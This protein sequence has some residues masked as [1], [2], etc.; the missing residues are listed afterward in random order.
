MTVY[1][2]TAFVQAPEK[3]YDNKCMNHSGMLADRNN[4]ANIELSSYIR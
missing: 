2:R 3:A 4:G 1:I